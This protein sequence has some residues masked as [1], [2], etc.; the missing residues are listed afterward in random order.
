MRPAW[1]RSYVLR[2]GSGRAAFARPIA[3]DGAGFSGPMPCQNLRFLVF[4]QIHVGSVTQSSMVNDR[5][6]RCGIPPME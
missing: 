6:K 2:S 3:S 4:M 5:R 1:L